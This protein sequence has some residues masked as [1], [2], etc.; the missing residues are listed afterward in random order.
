MILEERMNM[1]SSP[2]KIALVAGA[3]KGIG[4]EVARQ[5]AAGR[6][7]VL[8]GARNKGIR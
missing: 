7:T 3:N 1:Q 4:F 6:C 5:L 8:L 2:R